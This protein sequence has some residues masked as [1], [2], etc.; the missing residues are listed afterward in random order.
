[1]DITYA[2]I[3]NAI[4]DKLIP[5]KATL[6]IRALD[7]YNGDFDPETIA[8]E[9]LVFPAIFVAIE[10][11][12]SSQINNRDNRQLTV[13]VYAAAKNV[14]GE[15]SQR[16]GDSRNLGVYT[17]LESIRAALNRQIVATASGHR[18]SAMILKS[19]KIVAHSKQMGLCIAVAEYQL[20]TAV[21]P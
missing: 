12:I 4:L 8:I 20:S 10:E 2:E 11:M 17:L 19:E 5:L 1:M 13:R 3:E 7:G 16:R 9:A 15:A 14:R 6:G 21:M 18:L